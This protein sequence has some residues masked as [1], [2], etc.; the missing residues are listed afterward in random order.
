VF[1][2][3]VSGHKHYFC[4]IPIVAD[5]EGNV[6]KKKKAPWDAF[7]AGMDVM[8]FQFGWFLVGYVASLSSVS[9]VIMPP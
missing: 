2:S 6:K 3:S 4:L 7:W 9:S 5:L 8:S 1:W